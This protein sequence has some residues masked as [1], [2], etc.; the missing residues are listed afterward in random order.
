MPFQR[1]SKT[2]ATNNFCC[3][4]ATIKTAPAVAAGVASHVWTL[5]EVVAMI[6]RHHA[7]KINAEF[8]AAF[9]AANLTPQRTHSKTYRPT[10]KDQI[11][12]P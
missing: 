5:E 6:D 12:V 2:T 11:P 10:P 4:H 8:E 7:D 9:A 3:K 1:R